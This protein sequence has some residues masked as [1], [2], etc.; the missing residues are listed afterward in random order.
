[1]RDDA[2]ADDDWLWSRFLPRERAERI[3]QFRQLHPAS[4]EDLT[5]VTILR[6]IEEVELEAA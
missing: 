1:M 4:S 5:D 3:A 2:D 6:I